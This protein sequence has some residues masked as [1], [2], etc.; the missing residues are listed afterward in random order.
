[1][2]R[3]PKNENDLDSWVE[4]ASAVIRGLAQKLKSTQDE[5]SKLKE[6]NE[7][8]ANKLKSA[9]EAGEKLL[10]VL[11][12]VGTMALVLYYMPKSAPMEEVAA[13]PPAHFLPSLAA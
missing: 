1:M 4:R 2:A 9:V 3:A 10:P 6:S 5:N 11:V 7:K 8:A 13:N 12:A